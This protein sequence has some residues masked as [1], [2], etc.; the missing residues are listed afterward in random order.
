MNSDTVWWTVGLLVLACVHP[1]VALGLAG[2]VV[3]RTL[4]TL[5]NR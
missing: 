2:Y 4:L 5:P 1:A 3:V